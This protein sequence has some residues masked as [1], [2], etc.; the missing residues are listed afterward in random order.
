MFGAVLCLVLI[1][2]T[3]GR[4]R[5]LMIFFSALMTAG[6]GAMALGE[7]DNLNLMY[8]LVTIA[9]I[10]VGGVIVPCTVITTIICPDDLV[11]TITALTLSIR[12]LGGAVGFT[13]YYNVFYRRLV[14]AVTNIVG[15][16]AIIVQMGIADFNLATE[17]A[18]LSANAQFRQLREVIASLPD[19]IASKPYAFDIIVEAT[20]YA[21]AVAYKWPYYISI[22][23]GLI[24]FICSCFLGDIRG[25]MDDHVAVVY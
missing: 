4:I 15:G 11:A 7:V 19:T 2:V 18:T 25:F 3:K 1:G 24:S 13:V 8:G 20:Q 14:P 17:M 10:G 9:S 16:R 23:F 21:F 5:E 6:T 22:A 12:V